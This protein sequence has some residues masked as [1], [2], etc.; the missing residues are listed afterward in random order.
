VKSVLRSLGYGK[1]SL[2]FLDILV[3]LIVA[4]TILGTRWALFDYPIGT[5]EALLFLLSSIFAIPVFREFQLYKHKIFSTGSAQIVN[6]GKGMLWV[7]ILQ[8]VAIFLIKDLTVIGYSRQNILMYIFG[9]WLSLAA[10]RVGLFRPLHRRMYGN[11]M[12]VHRILAVGAGNSGQS[13]ATR[14]YES[15]ELGLS[16]VGFIDDDWSI[17]GK[18]LLGQKIYGPVSDVARIAR[19]LEADEIYIAINSIEYNR[20]LEIIETCRQT[21]LPVT[22]TTTH[23]RI[24]HDK[25]GTSEFDFIDSLTL[26]PR[27]LEPASRMLKRSFDMVGSLILLTLLSPFLLAISIAVKLTSE[28]PIFYRS[29]VV[30]K[31]GELFTWFKFRTMINSRTESI[32]REHLKKIITENATTMKLQN[33]PRITKVGRFLR[34]YSL[35]ELP[36]LFNVLRGEMSLIGPRPCLQYEYEHFDDWHKQRFTVIPG[37]TGLWQVFGRNRSDVTFN[38]SIILDLY[39]IQNYSLWLDFRIILK[40]IPIVLFGRG[41]A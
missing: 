32:H 20:L 31:D 39:Y 40:T 7:G 29:Q 41:G 11:G 23:F 3:L 37:M 16:L 12:T 2:A 30:G 19:E 18:R 33:D 28:G 27:G 1:L 10:V 5:N 15:P 34:K 17:I 6:I 4:V 36:Q 25:I 22:V 8:V 13:L 24:I 35:D 21:G 38:D 14:L 9:G 26:R